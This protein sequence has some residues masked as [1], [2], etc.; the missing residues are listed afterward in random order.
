LPVGNAPKEGKFTIH[1]AEHIQFARL[2]GSDQ[3][4][5]QSLRKPSLISCFHLHLM[6]PKRLII[7]S[8]AN[9][10]LSNEFLEHFNQVFEELTDARL[11]TLIARSNLTQKAL[12][13]PKN[14]EFPIE[15]HSFHEKVVH[16]L[17]SGVNSQIVNV[18]SLRSSH[19]NR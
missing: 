8:Q 6:H 3:S 13:S 18:E 19:G 14:S 1:G 16:L 12:T 17:N 4:A 2:T 9:I 5:N 15:Y 10:R 7:R 11:I